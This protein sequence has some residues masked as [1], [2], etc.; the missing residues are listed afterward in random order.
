MLR[1]LLVVGL[2]A[3]A[4]TCQAD[5]IDIYSD[6]STPF[7]PGS[8]LTVPGVSP[9]IS[10]SPS[11][12]VYLTEIDFVAAVS[13][14]QALADNPT[15]TLSVSA[16]DSGV[17]SFVPTDPTTALASETFDVTGAGNASDINM[18]PPPAFT[19][20]ILSDPVIL[21]AGSTYWLTFSSDSSGVFWNG[22][23][24]GE[25]GDATYDGTSWTTDQNSA[26]GVV[27][28][29][30]EPTPEPGTFA[31]LAGAFAAVVLRRRR[32]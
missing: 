3:L 7:S 1:F 26:T 22:D 31:L 10:F 32:P 5:V 16:D 23:T 8:G 2:G 21:D 14:Y 6:T 27:D 15:I 18:A 4:A 19:D 12:N 29:Q 25:P 24:A 13:R 20:W 28:I 11:V 17:P 30:G 9:S